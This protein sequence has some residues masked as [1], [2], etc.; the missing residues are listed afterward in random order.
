MAVSLFEN[1]RWM[2]QRALQI[3]LTLLYRKQRFTDP[4]NALL[5]VIDATGTLSVCTARRL[6]ATGRRESLAAIVAAT[7]HPAQRIVLR[8][9]SV[10]MQAGM[11][12]VVAEM[13]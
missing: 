13:N 1:C 5:R 7:V 6:H 8:A 11:R 4:R 3:A 9:Q 10:Q 2:V 12:T